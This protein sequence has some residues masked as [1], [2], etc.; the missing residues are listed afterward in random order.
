MECSGLGS[1]M[2][3]VEFQEG[4]DNATVGKLPGTVTYPDIAL[5]WNVTDS[6][7]LYQWHLPV[8]QGNL[9]RQSRSVVSL[10][11]QGQG[12]L[13]RNFLSP[14][15]S[16]WMGPTLNAKGSDVAI[17]ELTLACERQEPPQ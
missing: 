13:R 10:D 14:W 15:P 7:E 16:E 17:E 11:A 8:I 3:V 9:E 1:Q 6:Q 2:E 5:N 12:K 4:G